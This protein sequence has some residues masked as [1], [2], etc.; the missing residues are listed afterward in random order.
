[1]NHHHHP[2][3]PRNEAPSAPFDAPKD[4]PEAVLLAVRLWAAVRLAPVRTAKPARRSHSS[5]T[6]RVCFFFLETKAEMMIFWFFAPKKSRDLVFFCQKS[7]RHL[8]KKYREMG[9]RGSDVT[10]D[11]RKNNKPSCQD[12]HES[13]G[14]IPHH[15]VVKTYHQ[16]QWQYIGDR[17]HWASMFE[18][19]A[20]TF[21]CNWILKPFL[22]PKVPLKNILKN[23]LHQFTW[24]LT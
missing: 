16:E 3:F 1:M 9:K 23:A 12:Y 21:P 7:S 14:G 18:T 15:A 10:P 22:S 5:R 4:P 6:S 13:W 8:N 24:S 20:R 19:L 11:H 17:I 2:N